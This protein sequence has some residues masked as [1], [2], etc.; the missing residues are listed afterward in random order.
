MTRHRPAHRAPDCARGGRWRPS[1]WA[2]LAAALAWGGIL[3]ALYPSAASW[4]FDHSKAEVVNAYTAQVEAG[5]DPEAST[6]LA[7]AHAY[8]DALKAGARL[9]ANERL[10]TGDGSSSDPGL[11][12]DDI[13]KVDSTGLMGRLSIPSI[14]VDLPVYH[15]TSDEVL[16]EGLGHLQGTSLPVGGEGTHS[17]ITGHRG[18]ASATL[19]TDLD[20]VAVGDTFTLTV[21]DQVLVYQV[22]DT[23]VVD[24]DQTESLGPVAGKDLV[25][26]VTCTPLGINSQRILVTG[27]RILPAPEADVGRASGGAEGP[28]FP[29]W[30]VVAVAVTVG[31]GVSVWRSGRSPRSRPR[32][33]SNWQ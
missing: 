28:G 25:T 4:F 9:E 3:L 33:T 24:P 7:E 19:F 18:L 30:A 16:L 17:V 13:L 14:D 21:L 5:L 11:V 15:G 6:Q 1:P 31:A 12:Y 22:T 10:P 23:R 32:P 2:V 26:L 20:K 8:N 27:E 29:W